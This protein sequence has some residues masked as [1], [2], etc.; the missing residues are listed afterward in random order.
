MISYNRDPGSFKDPS[1]FVFKADG[2]VY[3][4]VNRRYAAEYDQLMG[5]GLYD[6]LTRKKLLIGHEEVA[7]NLTGSE[8]WYKTLKPDQLDY[9]SYP[10][11]WSFDQLRDAGLLTLEI[12]RKAID[13]GMILKDATPFNVQFVHG[14]PL[15]ID[16]LS[17]DL[18]DTSKPWVAYRQFC[19]CFLFPLYLGHYLKTGMQKIMTGYYDGVPLPLMV[20]LLPFK[21]RFNAGVWLH[22]FLQHK[23]ATGRQREQPA[24]GFSKQKMVHLLSHLESIL[25]KLPSPADSTSAWSDYYSTSIISQDYLHHKESIIRAWLQEIDAVTVLD[26]G[27]NDG[28][29]SRILAEK[30]RQVIATD[31]DIQCINNL[32]LYTKKS[33]TG[34]ILPLVVD[35]SNPSPAIGFSNRERSSFRERIQTELVMALALVHHLV[36]GRNI[37]LT[38][39]AAWLREF[40]P[41]LVIEFVGR[42]DEKVKEMLRNRKDIFDDYTIEGFEHAFSAC[43]V[44]LKKEA[45]PQTDRVL[46]YMKRK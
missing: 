40:A 20:K 38:A 10:Y 21:S 18:Y 29:F 5:S 14:A 43:F 45:V 4:Q 15:F 41:Q 3:R 12:T 44:I 22:L 17:F 7:S 32:Y 39:L 46:Y 2:I 6:L 36:I 33:K 37:P 11:E 13:H 35:A 23:L 8:D 16:T 24:T 42:Q 19:E 25:Q 26:L 34:N 9:L 27:A 31:T 1:G 28:H 30:G